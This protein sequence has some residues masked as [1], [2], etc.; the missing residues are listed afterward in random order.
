IARPMPCPHGR[1]ACTNPASTMHETH[2]SAHQS[3]AGTRAPGE[4][5]RSPREHASDAAEG[6][7][8]PILHAEDLDR[9][10]SFF[11]N[12]VRTRPFTTL[13]LCAAAGWVAGRFLR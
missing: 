13:L 5:D 8:E 12:Q 9:V 3:D 7:R 4:H 11:E 2:F 1:T 10:R 6:H